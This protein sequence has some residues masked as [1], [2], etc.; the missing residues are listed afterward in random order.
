MTFCI[1]GFGCLVLVLIVSTFEHI[2]VLAASIEEQ[3][4]GNQ[5]QD[6]KSIHTHIRAQ[7]YHFLRSLP[8]MAE[9][10]SAYSTF[11]NHY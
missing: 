4:A 3:Q 1:K 10:K 2:R 7:I 6:Y 5:K 8:K 9:E 11:F